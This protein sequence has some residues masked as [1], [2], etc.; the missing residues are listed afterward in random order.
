LLRRIGLRRVAEQEVALLSETA[1]GQYEAYCQGVNYCL[2]CFRSKLPLEFALVRAL[3]PPRP[4]WRPEPWT[5]V[6]SL[7]FGKLMA[8][9]LSTNWSTELV[10]ASLLRAVGPV[11]AAAL[12]PFAP[13]SGDG[14]DA[15]SLPS[16][17]L[18]S[19][20]MDSYAELE[21]FLS[22]AGVGA[23]GFS[24]AWAVN[25]TRTASGKPLL[26]GDPHLSLQ[27]PSLWYE[28][29]LTGPGIDVNGASLPGVPGVLIGRNEHIA[30][31]ITAS[32]VDVQDL[33][34]EQ[35][36]PDN[37]L[38]YRF[39]GAWR[40]GTLVRE[41][42]RVHGKTAPV[43]E[44]VL[45]THHGP[46]LS[47]PDPSSGQALALRWTALQPGV[48][49]EAVL[50]LDRAAD[51]PG[52]TAALRLWD[53]PPMNFVYA[54]NAGNI[55][56]VTAGRVPIRSRG[57]G[58]LPVPGWTG[59]YEWTG[60][61]PFDELPQVFNP[62]S[63]RVVSANER[64]APAEYP[65][66]LGHEWLP[67]YRAR[68]IAELLERGGKLTV[69]DFRQMQ[70]DVYS[71]PGKEA[72]ALLLELSQAT[73]QERKAQTAVRQWDG[74][75]RVDSVGGCLVMVFQHHL[76]RAVFQP[77]LGDLAESYLGTGTSPLSPR[78][79]FF[80]R[81]LP[82]LYQ[83]AR[84]HDDHW[85]A[86]LGAPRMTWDGAQ[87]GAWEATLAF[88]G[89]RLGPDMSTWRWG[90][91]NQVA[92]NHLL[93]TRAPLDRWL[94]RGPL[95]MGGDDNT[96]AAAVVPLHSPHDRN[97]WASSYRQIVDL[98]QAENSLAM[99]TTGQSGHPAS[100]HYDD[101]FDAWRTGRYHPLSLS[102]GDPR[103]E[104]GGHLVLQ[105]AGVPEARRR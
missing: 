42:I 64:P 68:R 5:I 99:H 96:I 88:L 11:R 32:M 75:L 4:R 103:R 48:L 9:A 6:D 89:E 82:M 12:E 91:L 34:I 15:G 46:V 19:G 30:W 29:G 74:Y 55:G 8:L 36:R 39:Q 59:E 23:G 18:L 24:N 13:S 33:V 52:F 61:I 105:P 100:E 71:L 40:E 53:A 50:A 102:L 25:G 3:P 98:G 62:P 93:G 22:A 2:G 37:P 58:M 28:L 17:A 85:F 7:V 77:L 49:G 10:R 94:S 47:V 79:G 95:E 72:A 81:A 92:F 80:T 63:G 60:S 69:E 43:V 70:Q 1:R 97:G 67:N 56:S 84:R 41:E 83:L 44:E 76:L 38:Q 16:A 78:N 54:D 27:M 45:V 14:P 104:L 66:H 73:D 57:D 35:L 20:L 86:R 31:S 21:P 51:W 87:R 26:A 90:R 65:Y 101:M